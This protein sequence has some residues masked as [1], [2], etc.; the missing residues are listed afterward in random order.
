M[1]VIWTTRIQDQSIGHFFLKQGDSWVLLDAATQPSEAAHYIEPNGWVGSFGPWWPKY[2][3]E[4]SYF[5][6]RSKKV[7]AEGS[8]QE[9]FWTVARIDI[10]KDAPVFLADHAG[11]T[12]TDLAHYDDATDTLYYYAASPEPRHRQLHAV[13]GASSAESAL[14]PKCI[15]CDL[16][17]KYPAGENDQ[18][19]RCGW[20]NVIF[21]E[22]NVIFNCRGGAGLPITLWKSLDSLLDETVEFTELETNSELEETLKS[23]AMP[24]KV[25]G[26]YQSNTYPEKT[27]N[28]QWFKP[29]DFDDSKKYPLVIEVYAGPEFQKVTDEWSPDFC[30][31]M[32][33]EY[34]IIC[35]SVDGRGSAWN[36]K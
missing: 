2:H 33:S 23:V 26:K 15:T 18:E 4:G 13:T 9:G 28:F 32:V 16:I 36:E 35:A 14:T 5:T 30:Q 17:T 10:G 34:D 27:F 19:T 24:K 20:I 29:D 21:H 7:G 12:D 25:Y 3:S 11:Y 6:L 8:G 31:S 22:N 1:V